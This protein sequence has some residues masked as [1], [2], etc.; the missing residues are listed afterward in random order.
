LRQGIAGGGLRCL[1]ALP[2][3][4][5]LL[6]LLLLLCERLRAHLLVLLRALLFL[7]LPL[8]LDEVRQSAYIESGHAASLHGETI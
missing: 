8:I 3:L 7:Q 6:P 4:L 1:C 2:V 5:R